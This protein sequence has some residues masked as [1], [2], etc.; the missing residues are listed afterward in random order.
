MTIICPRCPRMSCAEQRSHDDDMLVL[1]CRAPQQE[2]GTNEKHRCRACL[3]ACV[4]RTSARYARPTL[5]NHISSSSP[6]KKAKLRM[7]C[8]RQRFALI[9]AEDAKGSLMTK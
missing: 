8:V 7:L 5:D 6:T 1:F 4:M 9:S 3:P 2:G